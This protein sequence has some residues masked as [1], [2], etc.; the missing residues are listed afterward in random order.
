L[1]RTQGRPRVT[2]DEAEVELARLGFHAA[3]FDRHARGPQPRGAAGCD[4]VRI[5]HRGDDP[6]DAGLDQGIHA[7]RRAAMVVAGFERDVGGG[8]PCGVSGRPQ[9]TDFGM[10]LAGLLVPAFADD[11]AVPDEHAADAGIWGCGEEPAGRQPQGLRH[12][13]VI[14]G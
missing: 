6:S 3:Y 12:E 14:G 13:G 8:A 2:R 7:R 5:G 9:G 10:G 4:G 11:A 1:S